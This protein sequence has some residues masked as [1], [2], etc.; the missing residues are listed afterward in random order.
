MIGK[1]SKKPELEEKLSDVKK[2]LSVWLRYSVVA[3]RIIRY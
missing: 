3:K 2:R 1:K